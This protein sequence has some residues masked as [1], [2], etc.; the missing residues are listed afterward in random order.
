MGIAGRLRIDILSDTHGYLSEELLDELRGADYLVH[1]GDITSRSDL[2]E[3]ERIAPVHL[4]LGNNDY[5]YEYGP[6][7]GRQARF[8]I[9]GVRFQ[10][11]H[12]REQIRPK[13]ADV[14]VFGHTHRPVLEWD[15]NGTLIMN[16]GSPTSPRSKE[17]PTIGRLFVKDGQIFD[18]KIVQLPMDEELRERNWWWFL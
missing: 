10:V 5:P 8:T 4:C 16:P 9:G 7:I 6:S 11:V 13:T 17:G 2:Q 3:L 18:P 1:A 15:E 12:H 14:C